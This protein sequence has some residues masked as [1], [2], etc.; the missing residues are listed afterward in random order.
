MIGCQ[1]ALITGAGGGIGRATAC[2]LAEDGFAVFITDIDEVALQETAELVHNAGGKVD[3]APMDVT[4]SSDQKSVLSKIDNL[5][6][7]VNSAGIYSTKPYETITAEDFEKQFSTN[8]TAMFTLSQASAR[9]MKHNGRIINLSSRAALGGRNNTHYSAAKAAILGMTKSMALELAPRGIT[10]NAVA[11]G[12]VLT[13]M[14]RR[15]GDDLE[16]LA[17]ELPLGRLGEPEDIAHA[18]SYFADPR[19]SFITGQI[20]IVDGGRSIGGSNP[21]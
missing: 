4:S 12:V 2:R 11:P 14:L 6:V 17:Q 9:V 21:F 3:Y 16:Q 13:N 18:I 8:V 1:W 15:R 5:T 10:V 19:A 20:L 7:L